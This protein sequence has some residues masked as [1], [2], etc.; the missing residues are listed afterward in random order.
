M[1]KVE[2]LARMGKQAWPCFPLHSAPAPIT[3]NRTVSSGSTP[4]LELLQSL[5]QLT[6]RLHL[7]PAQ[8]MHEAIAVEPGEAKALGFARLVSPRCP[9]RSLARLA[10]T[11]PPSALRARRPVAPSSPSTSTGRRQRPA[12]T[13]AMRW[14]I[15]SRVGGHPTHG[16][17][18]PPDWSTSA[19]AH[20]AR[21]D[22]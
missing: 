2:Y 17:P 9:S 12:A 15:S 8:D 1:V 19:C 11:A 6:F 16:D 20:C 22:H 3:H 4:P 10:R 14:S 7:M 13:C 5:A 21:V 18:R